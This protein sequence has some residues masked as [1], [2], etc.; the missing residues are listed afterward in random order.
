MIQV[1]GLVP[2]VIMYVCCV[3]MGCLVYTVSLLHSVEST[4]T[5]ITVKTT[6]ELL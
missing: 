3:N 6:V 2:C 1:Y 4:S 5:P